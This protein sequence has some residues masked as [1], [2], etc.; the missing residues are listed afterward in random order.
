[1][2]FRQLF[3]QESST[4]TY[5]IACEKTRK[6]ALID[7][8]KSEIPQYLQ[9]LRE[10]NRELKTSFIVVTHDLALAKKLDQQYWMRDGHL[11]KTMDGLSHG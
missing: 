8:V 10:L 7:T 11:G 9:L 4:Y 5:L 2:I 6:A 1:M 3:E